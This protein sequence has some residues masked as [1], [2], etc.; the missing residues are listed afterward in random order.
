METVVVTGAAGFIGSWLC[1]ELAHRGYRVRAIDCLL[2]HSYDR[3]IKAR[4]WE[5]LA[6][7]QNIERFECDLADG[8]DAALLDGARWVVNQ[9][10]MPGLIKSWNEFALYSRNNIESVNN[11]AKACVEA[12]TPHFIQIST[13][14]VYGKNAVDDEESVPQPVSPYGVTKLAAEELVKAYSRT[15]GLRFSILRYFSVFGPRQRPD[16]AYYR[17]IDALLDGRAITIYGDGR[18]SR[19]NTFVEDICRGTI[20]SMNVGPTGRTYN[21]AG[22]EERS[23]VEA[24]A[25]VEDL[26]GVEAVLD[27]R[28]ARPGDQLRTRGNIRRAVEELGYQPVTSLRQGLQR[29]LN[30]QLEERETRPLGR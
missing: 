7:I 20:D 19:T 5:H 22:A 26:A 28:S 15:F 17:V 12:E 27:F 6:A 14:S 13:S 1:G 2:P 25:I 18:Q 24:I 9:A 21:L 4:N 30:W 23:L 11:L 29:Q 3:S 8:I 10:G 16:M